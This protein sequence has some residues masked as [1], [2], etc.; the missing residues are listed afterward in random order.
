MARKSNTLSLGEALDEFLAQYKHIHKI[1]ETEITSS[2]AVMMGANIN[3]LTNSVCY[4][5][6]TL[7]VYLKSAP[8][9][10]ELTMQ[11][12]KIA[13]AINKHLGADHVKEVILR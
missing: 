3:K 9:R 2:W 5:N 8:L 7:F 12:S 1:K 11:R 4:K 13:K 10:Q 6:G